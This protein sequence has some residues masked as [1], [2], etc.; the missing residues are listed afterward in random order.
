MIR[1]VIKMAVR[2]PESDQVPVVLCDLVEDRIDGVVGRIKQHGL[3]CGFVGD[4]KAIR[5]RDSTGI[6]QDL[7]RLLPFVR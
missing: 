1:N 7:H 5:R 2:Q 4:D 3:L 6:H